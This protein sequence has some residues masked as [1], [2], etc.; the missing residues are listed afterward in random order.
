[1]SGASVA[2]LEVLSALLLGMQ[3]VWNV[4]LGQ[5]FSRRLNCEQ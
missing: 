3:V 2:R 4:T 1:M 5:G